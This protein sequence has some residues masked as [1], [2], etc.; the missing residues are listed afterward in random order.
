MIDRVVLR[1]RWIEISRRDRHLVCLDWVINETSIVGG[2]GAR[3]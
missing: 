1:A 2:R 3:E